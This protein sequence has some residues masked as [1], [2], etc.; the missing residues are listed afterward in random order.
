[1]LNAEARLMNHP[2]VDD[3]RFSKGERMVSA[4]AVRS[5]LRQREGSAATATTA[6]AAAAPGTAKVAAAEIGAAK[7]RVAGVGPSIVVIGA[8]RILGIEEQAGAE[9]NALGVIEDRHVGGE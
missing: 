7:L 6:T 1:M 2:R 3:K 5:A 8:Q 4:G 9:G